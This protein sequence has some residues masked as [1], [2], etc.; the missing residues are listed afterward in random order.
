M[1]GTFIYPR[2]SEGSLLFTLA[3]FLASVKQGLFASGFDDG[4]HHLD[5]AVDY[6][7]QF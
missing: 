1:D 5:K 2:D 4:L 3:G 6:A 7:E